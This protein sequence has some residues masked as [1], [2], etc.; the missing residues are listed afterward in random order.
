MT[1][2]EQYIAFTNSDQPPSQKYKVIVILLCFVG[3]LWPF[4]IFFEC[5]VDRYRINMLKRVTL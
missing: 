1:G 3:L 5:R 4:S 2:F